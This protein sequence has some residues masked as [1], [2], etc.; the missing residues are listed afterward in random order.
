MVYVQA[1][2]NVGHEM[3]MSGR[4][5]TEL[6]D[7]ANLSNHLQQLVGFVGLLGKVFLHIGII[8]FSSCTRI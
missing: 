5:V 1:G 3:G 2:E 4:F 6:L 8:I 7:K